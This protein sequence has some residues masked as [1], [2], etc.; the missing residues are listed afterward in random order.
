MFLH[1]VVTATICLRCRP[2]YSSI[3]ATRHF[4]GADHIKITPMVTES[5]LAIVFANASSQNKRRAANLV[6]QK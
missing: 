6:A 4:G 5:W 2:L 1:L 3:S